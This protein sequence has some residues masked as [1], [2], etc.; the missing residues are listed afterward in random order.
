MQLN[1][2]FRALL[3]P[4]ARNSKSILTALI[5]GLFGLALIYGATRTDAVAEFVA[6]MIIIGG[7][8]L[9]I[10]AWRNWESGLKALLVM[11]VIEG[12]IRKW[13]LPSASELV[14]FYKDFLMVVV[15]ISY[16]KKKRKS[17]LPIRREIELFSMA[18]IAFGLYALAAMSNPKLPHPL[19]GLLGIKAYLLYVP[20]VFLVPRMFTTKEKLTTFLKWYLIIALPVASLSAIQFTNSDVNSPLNRYAWD[21][22]AIAASGMDLAVANFQD[23]AGKAYVRVTGPFSYISGLTIYLPT[24]FALLLG[25]I[26]QRFPGLLPKSLKWIYYLSLASLVATVFMTG[27]R[28]AV[29]DL[30]IVALVFYGIASKRNLIRRL[31]QAAIG[32]VLAYL[33]LMV[34]FPQAYDALYTR[35]FGE[36][37]NVQEGRGRIEEAFRLPLEEASYAGAFGYGVGATQNSTPVLMSKLKLPLGGERIP[38]AYE[39]ESGRLMLELGIT[40]YV[41]YLFLRLSILLML[42]RVCLAIKDVEAKSLAVAALAA[43]VVPLVVGGAVT[44]HTQSVYQWFLIG[45]PLAMLNAETLSR[46][47]SH[48]ITISRNSFAF[49]R[50]GITS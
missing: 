6:P 13:F 31:R 21:E 16:L 30:A 45:I 4:G 14:Y 12:A 44:Q 28:S 43:L 40:G 42:L 38:I 49:R 47:A 7:G 9:L 37:E 22:Q 39:G 29:I 36:N 18:L 3:M 15:L 35:A 19:V 50:I 41:L 24:M 48:V 1:K 25:L 20:L 23:S 33:L 11:V 26:S 34:F 10:L 17:S 8:L 32:G 5:T 46:G 27:S 2:P